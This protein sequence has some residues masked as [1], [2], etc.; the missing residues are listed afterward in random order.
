LPADLPGFQKIASDFQNRDYGCK[1][2]TEEEI[3]RIIGMAWEDRTTFEEIRERTGLGEADVIKVMRAN[4]KRG[5]FRLWRKRVSGRITKHRK[6]FRSSR[7][8]LNRQ[9]CRHWLTGEG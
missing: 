7:E 3:N 8:A 4:L 9:P 1:T 5:S 2:V 6:S